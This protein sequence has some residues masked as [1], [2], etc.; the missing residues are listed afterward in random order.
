MSDGLIQSIYRPDVL[1]C[2]SN[3]SN[4]EVFTPPELANQML[5]LLPQQLFEDPNTKF[6]DPC[7]KSG[8]FLR[9]IAKR[10]IKGL[11]E[12]IPN[13]QDRIDHI[14][15]NQLFGIAITELTSLL[16]RR[17]LYC[18]KYANSRYS[19]SHFITPDGNIR[20]K[21]TQHTWEN[22]KCKYCGATQREYDRGFEYESHAYEWIHTISP[23]D[24]FNMKFDVC[25]SNPP[26]QLEVGSQK[27]KYAV[28][29]YDK[30]VE[31][32]KKLN[33]KYITM[34]IPARW[35][36]GGRGLEKFRDEMLHDRKIKVL[37]HYPNPYDCFK[38][39]DNPGGICYFLWSRDY[40]GDCTFVSCE[41]ENKIQT[42]RKLDEYPIFI[43]DLK[44]LNF[45]KR[46]ESLH[47]NDD[48]TLDKVVSP[49]NPF[50]IVT[51]Y[52][53]LDQGIPCWFTSK[54]GLKYVSPNDLK[55]DY[56]YLNKF[57]VLIPKAPI[58][59][60][61][62]FTK[63]VGIYY[64]GN[65]LIAN[66]GECCSQT[67]LVANAFISRNEA[68]SFRSYLLTKTVR[69]LLLQTVVSQD[70]GRNRF[71]FVPAL[72]TYEDEFTDERLRKMWNITD[73]EWDY[74]NTRIRNIGE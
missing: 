72:D 26:Y 14:M 40:S 73:D 11:E 42:V 47:I 15:H 74:I 30:F 29:L 49:Q 54:I 35:Y 32:C 43:R 1:L 5:D 4:D 41:G 39:V 66:P 53:P 21:K 51:S 37:V 27:D 67:W 68:E 17:S 59:G 22:G 20:F 50:G 44:G 12:K 70:I 55:D 63:P 45:I 23:E 58:A 2:L 52:K 69:F 60:Q 48:K 36:S 6:L 7:C 16:S 64:K 33:P 71:C 61:T 24:I 46:I 18:S 13:L 3:L 25:I 65:T 10:L 38:G 56:G 9:E 31:Q 62:D 57:K 19:I 8:V 34:I 28:P